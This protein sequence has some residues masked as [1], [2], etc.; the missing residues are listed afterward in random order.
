[1]TTDELI[2]QI[3]KAAASNDWSGIQRYL[4]QLKY[5]MSAQGRPISSPNAYRLVEALSAATPAAVSQA[6]PYTFVNQITECATKTPPD[7]SGLRRAWNSLF[8]LVSN[9]DTKIDSDAVRKVLEACRNQRA[10]DLVTRMADRALLREA[11]DARVRNIYAQA[12]IDMGQ[13][14][15]AVDMLQSVLKLPGLQREQAAEAKGLLGRANKQ[16]YVDNVK[17][18]NVPLDIRKRFRP[19]L[20]NAIKEYA[21]A[22]DPARPGEN[23]WHGSQTI[24]LMNLAAEDGHGDIPNPCSVSPDELARRIIAALKPQ[25]D[26]DDPDAWIS[27]AIG[28]CYLALKDYENA[29]KYFGIFVRH[30]NLQDFMLHGTVRQ[31]EEVW[32]I[33]PQTSGA[34]PLLARLKEAQIKRPEG[35]FTIPNQQLGKLREL[36]D[37]QLIESNVPGGGYVPLRE[38][39]IVV[40]RAAGVI[41]VRSSAG[42][43][44]GTGFLFKGSDLH[45]KLG[46]AVYLMTNAHVMTDPAK[47]GHEPGTI[48]PADVRLWLESQ[49]LELKCEPVAVWQSPVARHD[50]TIV[51]ITSPISGAQMLPISNE[52]ESLQVEGPSEPPKATRVSV[53]GHPKGGPLSLSI[54]GNALSGANGLLVDMGPRRAGEDD[55][56]YLHYRAPTEPGNSGS[57]VFETQKWSVIGLHHMGFDQFDGR[58]KLMGR[59]GTNHAN[60]GICIKSI[61]RAVG[62]D[63]G[64]QAPTGGSVKK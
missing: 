38:L 16:I 60:E 30:R 3:S 4:A 62:K 58:A 52:G 11:G 32:R 54:V 10:F 24:A 50:A 56:V 42:E 25:V 31:I 43:T 47:V 12:L 41:A 37:S 9:F 18:S 22:V 61:R 49:N 44:Y 28:Q 14:F 59:P 53:I 57:P 15:A 19:Y 7:M 8:E 40:Q 6:D 48:G 26:N 5:M 27:G 64:G 51:R 1:M 2:A 36:A 20:E 33:T 17:S 13:T 23:Y 46:D 39:Q 34:G 35:R 29:D 21:S 45:A 55:P 63:L